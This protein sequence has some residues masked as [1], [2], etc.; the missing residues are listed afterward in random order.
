MERMVGTESA[1]A[2]ELDEIIYRIS[3]DLR[4]SVRALRDLP[5]WLDEDLRA[6]GFVPEG[7]AA[8]TLAL[9]AE[10]A[11]RLEAMIAG[12]LAYSRVGRLQAH[13]RHLPGEVFEG[14]VADLAPGPDV[15][16]FC[17]FAP[18]PV[19]MGEAD[20][21]KVFQVLLSN[22][23]AHARRPDRRLEIE[24]ASCR[25]GDTWELLFADNGPG[26]APDA[27]DRVFRPMVRQPPSSDENGSEIGA[28]MGLAILR[29]IA[30]TYGGTIDL[31]H[32]RRRGGTLFRLRL[33]VCAD[34]VQASAP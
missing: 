34:A 16:F 10:H 20:V 32:R 1:G 6:Q 31:E 8:E 3:H 30:A 7:D 18:H 12:L 27:A 15:A 24:I 5:E 17:Q 22:A 21:A 4:A 33:P 13:A 14:L 11:T 19:R 28:G 25:S 9:M 26:I 29:K 23:L 2:N